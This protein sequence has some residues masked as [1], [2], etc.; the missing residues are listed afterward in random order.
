[1]LEILAQCDRKGWLLKT[2]CY[3]WVND[4]A[5]VYWIKRLAAEL[6]SGFVFGVAPTDLWQQSSTVKHSFC[7][8]L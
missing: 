5:I 6:Q 4:V 1:V 7:F 8:F 2:S 3:K